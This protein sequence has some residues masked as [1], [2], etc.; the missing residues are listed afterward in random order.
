MARGG[1][2]GSTAPVPV[3]APSELLRVADAAAIRPASFA[4]Y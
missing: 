3:V 4:S 2:H 1:V